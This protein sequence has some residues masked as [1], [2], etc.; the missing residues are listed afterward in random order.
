MEEKIDLRVFKTRKALTEAM[1]STLGEKK[2]EDITVQYICDKAMVRRAT[3]YTHFVDKY[4]LFAYTVRVI[5]KEFPSYKFLDNENVNRRDIYLNLVEEFVIFITENTK[6][7]KALLNSEVVPIIFNIIST[8]IEK[9]LSQVLTKDIAEHTD[10]SP[11]LVINF[12][13][14]GVLGSCLWWINENQPIS[15]EE[16]IKQIQNLILI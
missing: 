15:K 8:E 13:I 14:R 16:L 10:L 1:M 9:T 11:Q 6:I 4:E 2:F 5:Y 7:V 12:Y 3:F